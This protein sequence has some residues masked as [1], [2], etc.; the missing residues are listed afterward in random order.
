[1]THAQQL[2]Q[3]FSS[4]FPAPLEA[5]E[6]FAAACE[7]V[8]FEKDAIMKPAHA[9]E[10]YFYFILEG[11]VG[12]FLWKENNYVCLDFAFE[13]QFCAD[14]MSLLT[15]QPNP[16]Q[17][18]ALEKSSFLRMPVAEYDALTRLP[19][20]QLIRLVAAEMSFID[21]QQQQIELLTMPAR[22]RYEALLQKFPN[23]QNRIAQHHLA[24]Y[25]GITPQS[26]SRIRREVGGK[27]SAK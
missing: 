27:G 24:S 7:L 19:M 26:L 16:L 22:V 14:Y 23:I 15:K 17:L 9:A 11:S 4:F 20:G 8:H 2:Q 18:M 21:K 6:Q 13:Q 25:L 5:W 10:R 1:M 12:L 3:A